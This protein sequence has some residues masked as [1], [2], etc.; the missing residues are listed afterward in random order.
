MHERRQCDEFRMRKAEHR[1]D[2][3][4]YA[5]TA[6]CSSNGAERCILLGDIAPTES[7]GGTRCGRRSGTHGGR[8][9]WWVLNR[10]LR[11]SGC[12][13]LSSTGAIRIQSALRWVLPSVTTTLIR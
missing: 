8:I 7:G 12:V 9:R 4:R 11:P 2:A 1:A 5:R 13:G 10:D 3:A 6:Q